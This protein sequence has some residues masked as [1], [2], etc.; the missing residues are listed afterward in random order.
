[1][2]FQ[3]QPQVCIP[4]GYQGNPHAIL[5]SLQRT[6]GHPAPTRC[7]VF[8]VIDIV[9]ACAMNGNMLGDRQAGTQKGQCD[10]ECGD[11]K[12]T[13]QAH[14]FCINVKT[15]LMH[16]LVNTCKLDSY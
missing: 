14:Y 6:V 1:M 12:V 15:T 5:T 3:F 7:S 9:C 4:V 16:M 2:P 8:V 10:D 13:M 11:T